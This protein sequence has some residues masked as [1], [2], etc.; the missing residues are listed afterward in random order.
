[1]DYSIVNY[2]FL[3]KAALDQYNQEH[4]TELQLED[5]LKQAMDSAELAAQSFLEK[6]DSMNVDHY[7]NEGPAIKISE[8]EFRQLVDIAVM[9]KIKNRIKWASS[10]NWLNFRRRDTILNWRSFYIAK[11]YRRFWITKGP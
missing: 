6:I 10:K 4:G 9:Q 1:M 11:F 7:I 5:I 8:P 3:K 2:S